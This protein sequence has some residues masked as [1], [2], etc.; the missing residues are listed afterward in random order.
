MPFFTRSISADFMAWIMKKM[1]NHI[2]CFP[3]S[4]Y[5]AIDIH[6]LLFDKAGTRARCWKLYTKAQGG[7]HFSTVRLPHGYK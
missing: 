7:F 6:V 2:Q 1:Y 3:S 5:I 4:S